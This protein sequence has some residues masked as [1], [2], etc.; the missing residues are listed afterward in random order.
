MKVLHLRAK[1]CFLPQGEIDA[2][3]FK[4]WILMASRIVLIDL[5]NQGQGQ[6]QKFQKSC[7]ISFVF[8]IEEL[9]RYSI[10]QTSPVSS[11][12]I[13][14]LHV[15]QI[16]FN[17]QHKQLSKIWTQHFCNE[18]LTKMQIQSCWNIFEYMIE[19]YSKCRMQSN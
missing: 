13:N 2:Q 14:S 5:K 8:L 15:I 18:F 12:K 19:L 16:V 7:I 10:S 3:N 17:R 1:G 9:C 4:K 11:G 6:W